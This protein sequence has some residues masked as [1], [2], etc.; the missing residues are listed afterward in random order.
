MKS[1][2]K[3]T[4]IGFIGIIQNSIIRYVIVREHSTA[5]YP[6]EASQI[7][8]HLILAGSNLQLLSIVRSPLVITSKIKKIDSNYKT[9]EWI[10]VILDSSFTM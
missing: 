6:P 3:I 7:L 10:K 5:L 4:A 9:Q 1:Q 2:E 8:Q